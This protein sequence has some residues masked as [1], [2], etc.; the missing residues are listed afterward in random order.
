MIRVPTIRTNDRPNVWWPRTVTH[1][2]NHT[3]IALLLSTWL[4]APHS[5]F[6]HGRAN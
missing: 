4:K 1:E 3:Q 2:G 6:V 5:K